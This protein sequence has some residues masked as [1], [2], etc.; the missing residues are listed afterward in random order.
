MKV[1]IVLPA[2]G[3][4][5]VEMGEGLA[6]DELDPLPFVTRHGGESEQRLARKRRLDEGCA[7]ALHVNAL[8]GIGQDRKLTVALERKLIAED[9]G[10]QRLVRSLDHGLEDAAADGQLAGG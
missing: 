8:A 3:V 5:A 7:G 9:E 2:D 4:N 10:E 1:R 6:L